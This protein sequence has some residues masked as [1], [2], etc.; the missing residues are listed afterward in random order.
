MQE[1]PKI[2]FSENVG[3]NI[4]VMNFTQLLETL[5]NSKNHSPF[6]VHKIQFYMILVVTEKSYSHFVDFKSYKLTEGSAIFIAKNQVHHFTK[7]LQNADG[8]AII[9]NSLFTEKYSLLQ[10]NLKL[11]RLFNYHIE[12]PV[13]HQ[14]EMKK[15]NFKDISQKLFDEYHHPNT[16]AKSEMLS[17]LLNVLLL[18]SERAKEDQSFS[19]IKK[20]WLQIFNSFKNLLEHNYI[21]TRSSRAYASKL[22]VSYKLLNDIVKN[23][24]GKTTKVFIDD[25]VTIEIKRYLASTPLSIKE[26]SYKTGFDEPSN[27][28]K[29]FKKNTNFTPLQFRQQ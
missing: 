18:K 27:M 3:L 16:F 19:G 7:Q 26:I 21:E 25:F 9:F 12:A 1:I 28:V 20:H 15:D 8:F 6:E 4:E 14:K 29:F 13:I 23:L 17:S 10:S 22:H 5:N 24:T 2:I 11:N